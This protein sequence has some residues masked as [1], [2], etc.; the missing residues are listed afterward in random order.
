MEMGA[1]NTVLRASPVFAFFSYGFY[2]LCGFSVFVSF[3]V[4]CGFSVFV[5]FR[6][7][8]SISVFVS[9]C[10]FYGF[11]VIVAV[12]FSGFFAAAFE[13]WSAA[14]GIPLA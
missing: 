14:L 3:R 11:P 6:V 1:A 10:V 9:F 2:G 5:S 7:F 4:F 8:Y 13:R 12:I